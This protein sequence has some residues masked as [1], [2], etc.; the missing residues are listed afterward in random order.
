MQQLILWK[1]VL[2]Q[3]SCCPEVQIAETAS[4]AEH[5]RYAPLPDSM[6]SHDNAVS[7]STSSSEVGGIKYLVWNICIKGHY[8]GN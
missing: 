6:V 3:S 4:P 7:F 2:P 5:S 1:N 8:G